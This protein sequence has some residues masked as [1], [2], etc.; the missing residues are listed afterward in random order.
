MFLAEVRISGTGGLLWMGL[1]IN[2]EISTLFRHNRSR[3]NC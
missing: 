1:D 3:M 2:L